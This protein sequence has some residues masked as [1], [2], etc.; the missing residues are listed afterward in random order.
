M[1]LVGER[2]TIPLPR[3]TPDQVCLEPDFI[4]EH[5]TE[6]RRLPWELRRHIDNCGICQDHVESMEHLL[7][8]KHFGTRPEKLFRR[9][10]L[11]DGMESDLQPAEQKFN[12]WVR[13]LAGPLIVLGLAAAAAAMVVHF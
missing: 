8:K 5:L 7:T 4:K 11:H 3:E 2:M 12:V 1:R 9:W 13:R 6:A 10:H